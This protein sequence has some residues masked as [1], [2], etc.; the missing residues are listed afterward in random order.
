MEDIMHREYF[1]NTVLSYLIAAGIIV[2]GSTLLRVFRKT[3]LI[4]LK[5]WT[6]STDSSTDNFI[7]GSLEKFALPALHVLIIYWGVNYLTLSE[8]A[9]HVLDIAI[10]VALTYFVLRI[11]SSS[12]LLLLTNRV[13]H[14]ERGEEKV[15]QLGGLMIIINIMLWT[16]GTVFL[17]DNL[18]YNVTTIITGLG[19]GGIA[20]ALAA[21]N[22][23]GDLFNYFVIFFDRPFEVG[24]FIIVDDKMGEVEHI[25]IK[26]TRLRSLGGEL[27]VIGNSNLTSSRIHN[28]QRMQKR[29]V[30]FSID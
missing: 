4:R 3:I 19:I 17:I 30:V 29:R 11:L 8:Q 23:L 14:Q 24:D 9:E 12:L 18:G 1:G 6:D 28:Y 20:I 16:L 13:K 2:V 21:Q 15:K 5:K 26:T 22:I 7:V 10:T 27:L 25:G